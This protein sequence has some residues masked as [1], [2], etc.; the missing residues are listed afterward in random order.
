MTSGTIHRQVRACGEGPEGPRPLLL[1]KVIK[2]VHGSGIFFTL[3]ETLPVPEM[4]SPEGQN[5]H[6]EDQ[7]RLSLYAEHDSALGEVS[8]L[9]RGIGGKFKHQA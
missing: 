5:E 8:D 7:E 1:Q 4:S 3:H 6:V 9:I 2:D